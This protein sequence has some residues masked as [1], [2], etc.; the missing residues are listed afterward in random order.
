MC[1]AQQTNYHAFFLHFSHDVDVYLLYRVYIDFHI[2]GSQVKVIFNT[3]FL[4]QNSLMV[5]FCRQH[6]AN[7]I[8]FSTN[9]HACIV[10]LTWYRCAPPVLFWHWPPFNLFLCRSSLIGTTLRAVPSNRYAVLANYHVCIAMPTFCSCAPSQF[11]DLDLHLTCF[12]FIH[13]HQHAQPRILETWYP[14][15]DRSLF[16]FTIT[17]KN[18]II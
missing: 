5:P 18:R 4:S 3:D 17:G 8:P 16:I 7:A 1:S 9:Y 13:M 2:T 14:C 10:M 15:Y 11:L 12:S 6:P